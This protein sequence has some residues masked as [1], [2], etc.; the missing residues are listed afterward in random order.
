MKK[1]EKEV[2]ARVPERVPR[3]CFA[4][5]RKQKNVLRTK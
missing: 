3:P 2:T 5:F 4:A 1:A